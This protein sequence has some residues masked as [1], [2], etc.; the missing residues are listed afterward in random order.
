MIERNNISVTARHG[1]SELTAQKALD[2]LS[3]PPRISGSPE[4]RKSIESARLEKNEFEKVAFD[5]CLKHLNAYFTRNGIS[6]VAIPPETLSIIMADVFGTLLVP[7]HVSSG[8]VDIMGRTIE[9]SDRA[10][11][12]PLLE[13]KAL[14]HEMTQLAGKA[15]WRAT[16][17]YHDQWTT[18]AGD[19]RSRSSM[20]TTI[21]THIYQW[22]FAVAGF[23]KRADN[24]R[25][26]KHY[27]MGL[28]EAIIEDLTKE[29][30][31]GVTQEIANDTRLKAYTDTFTRDSNI[32][33]FTYPAQRSVFRYLCTEIA[34]EHPELGDQTSIKLL[35]QRARFS[36]DTAQIMHLLKT[37]FGKKSLGVI[38]GMPASDPAP[39]VSI[40]QIKTELAAL[41]QSVI[42]Q[43]KPSI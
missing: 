13:L 22:G 6:P 15:A 37:T 14:L 24:R 21:G 31:T 32:A 16:A 34:S 33:N 4:H 26:K 9:I 2:A 8:C 5:I 17:P 10:R 28:D 35:F 29:L 18:P 41:R 40:N 36:G 20:G 11:A 27:F 42:A 38:A 7:G 25:I 39:V 19:L 43:K 12:R 23:G 1:V 3:H 30:F